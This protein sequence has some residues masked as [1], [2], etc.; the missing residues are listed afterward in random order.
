[1]K[2]LSTGALSKGWLSGGGA[3]GLLRQ[4]I[5]V[6]DP[7]ASTKLI[8][9]VT[10][11]LSA[12][13]TLAFSG[14][15]AQDGPAP[16]TQVAQ[17]RALTIVQSRQG[18]PVQLRGVITFNDPAMGVAFLQDSTAG[19]FIEK[20]ASLE[21]VRAGDWVEV[22]GRTA[23]GDYAPV[24]SQPQVRRL[25]QAPLPPVQR[26]PLE[27]LLTGKEDSQWVEVRGVVHSIGIENRLPPDMRE[28]PGS[29]VLG[30]AAGGNQFKVRIAE[31]QKEVNY[32]YLIDD[33]IT[34]R[35][36]CGTL[37]NPKRQLTGIQ[38]FVPSLDQIHIEETGGPS[39]WAS[40]VSPMN[41]LMH[42]SPENA[43]GHRIRVRG[44]VT[45]AKRGQY[46]FAQ[47]ESG[48]VKVMLS[49]R[50]WVFQPGDV[51]DVIGFPTLG[52][53]APIL[54]DGE[55]HTMGPATPPTPVGLGSSRGF[56]SDQDAELVT[57]EGEAID[58][59]VSG[60]DFVLTVQRAG[61]IVSA[62][63]EKAAAGDL[64]RSLRMGSRL[65][66]TGVCLIETDE[67]RSPTAFQILLRSTQD[68]TVLNRPTW[69]TARR[70]LGLL[71]IAAAL[72]LAAAAWLAL[73]RR[74]VRSQSEAI[75]RSEAKYRSL[76]EHNLAGVFR[77]ALDGSLLDCNEA[78]A[79]ILGYESVPA[80]LLANAAASYPSPRARAVFLEKLK[81]QKRVTGYEMELKRTDGAH[82]H[83]LMN[84]NLADEPYGGTRVIEG[85]LVD[86]T[87]RKHAEEEMCKAQQAAEAANRAKS[88]FLANM[89][90]EI[91][92]PMNA[93]LGYSQLM[94]RDASLGPAAKENLRII[95]RSGEHLLNLIN[96]VLVMSK[97]E[98]GRLEL[99]AEAFDVSQLARDLE[100]MFRLRADAKG[101][102]LNVDLS[103]EPVREIVADQGKLRQVL[104]NLLGNAVKFTER[105]SI[106]L[107]VLID[108]RTQNRLWLS[109]DVQDTGLGM[110]EEEMA[111]LFQPFLQTRSGLKSQGGTGLGLAISKEFVRL[112][113]GELSVSS[114]A[115]VGSVFHFDVPVQASEGGVTADR[116]AYRR[117][118]GLQPG[119]GNPR[120]LV[121]DDE[122]NNR[123]WLRELLTSVGFLVSEAASGEEALKLW[124]QSWPHLI[125]MDMRLPG[126]D[127]R[128]ATRI[129][130]ETAHDHSPV[131]IALSA[132]ATT[133]EQKSAMRAGVD[134]FLSKPFREAAL[135]EKIQSHLKLN[136][137]YSGD[138][139][140][141][142]SG[143]SG[144]EASGLGPEVLAAVPAEILL[145]LR[146]AVLD[147]DKARLNQILV[148][149]A[150]HNAKAASALTELAEKYEY[151]ALLA[152]LE[153][154]RRNSEGVTKA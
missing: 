3:C 106:C 76:F 153:R 17:V 99:V 71:G 21:G 28:G 61:S 116:R 80:N 89:S 60:S 91:R 124:R 117:V 38:L 12:A 118:I 150:V 19:I 93:I 45:L 47:D 144:F 14:P 78:H 83:V 85:T 29:L 154:S 125:L 24:V 73:L 110:A 34:I 142:V 105:G 88:L 50:S 135:W 112:M 86:I 92:T 9:G 8:A 130:R 103:G 59:S 68:I 129:I 72:L 109:V 145:D 27:N 1:M 13:M 11:L 148:R 65:R 70:I 104:I 66:L 6:I 49:P 140:S 53:Y 149:V 107:R 57:I 97:V 114:Q 30:M 146:E 151:E 7:R 18:Y 64:I 35:G 95:N 58:E 82:I 139:T 84:A 77:S 143:P 75:G 111:G 46:L 152:L 127:G 40:I 23:P 48:G 79:R 147:G 94:L 67:Y 42:F 15:K 108:R 128:E 115:G 52:Q 16:L 123:G 81:A 120:V 4:I 26:F 2:L 5:H 138:E 132:G 25:G 44:V 22:S 62:R 87:E 102:A 56:S 113:G 33:A 122:P 36:V 98:A 137:V 63:I 20:N 55:A 31:F 134:D 69:W 10:V 39:P 41:S 141:S 90:H 51:V 133:E 121:V 96:D 131:I 32:D 101:L 100:S 136:Y 119:N 126:I 54:E 74:R 43:A 37:F